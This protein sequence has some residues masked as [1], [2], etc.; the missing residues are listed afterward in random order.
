MAVIN[1]T[2][3]SQAI[4]TM[5]AANA[6]HARPGGGGT[7]VPTVQDI[8]VNA[9]TGTVRYSTLDS[10]ASSA[11]TTVNENEVTLNMLVDETI[12]FGTGT[13]SDVLANVGLLQQS[14]NKTE[15]FFSVA[16]EGADSTDN[17][18]EGK[19]FIGGLA[20]SASIDAA[21]WISPMTIVVNGELTKGTV[22]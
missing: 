16:F 1:I 19:G 20:P 13:G 18:I 5:S 4:L 6:A 7:V 15:T 22:A 2:A 9:G 8:T 3:G 17:F 12:F 14:I 21:V 11:F 10:S